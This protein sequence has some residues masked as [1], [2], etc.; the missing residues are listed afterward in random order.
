MPD[1]VGEP[2][3]VVDLYPTPTEV[4]V[5]RFPAGTVVRVHHP[6]GPKEY[7]DAHD[8]TDPVLGDLPFSATIPGDR[9]TLGWGCTSVT[10][11]DQRVIAHGRHRRDRH[12][13]QAA[14]KAIRNGGAVYVQHEQQDYYGKLIWVATELHEDRRAL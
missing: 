8:G 2:M 9:E 3:A 14:V 6:S 10:Y 12:V 5:F 7:K 13:W 11:F 4:V 1:K